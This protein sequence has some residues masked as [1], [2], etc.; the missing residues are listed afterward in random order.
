MVQLEEGYHTLAL[1]LRS[2]QKVWGFATGEN[3][4]QYSGRFPLT[5]VNEPFF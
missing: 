2:K 5:C 1:G 4:I 3:G